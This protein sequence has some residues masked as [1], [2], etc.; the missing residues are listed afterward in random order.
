MLLRGAMV[1]DSRIILSERYSARGVPGSRA[2]LILGGVKLSLAREAVVH[3][4]RFPR[5]C[6][7]YDCVERAPS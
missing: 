6:R 1:W 3:D 2:S 4:R 7:V 5:L